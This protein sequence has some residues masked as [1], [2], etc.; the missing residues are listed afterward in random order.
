MRHELY[1]KPLLFLYCAVKLSKNQDVAE[2]FLG[3]VDF[4]DRMLSEPDGVP[5]LQAR[6]VYY[7]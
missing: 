2:V 3:C 5:G 7:Y 4:E 6:L 1:F